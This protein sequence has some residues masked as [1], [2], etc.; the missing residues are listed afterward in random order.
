LKSDYLKSLQKTLSKKQVRRD[1][2]GLGKKIVVEQ[3]G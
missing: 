3:M 1:T 2:E